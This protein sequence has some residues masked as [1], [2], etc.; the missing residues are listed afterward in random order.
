MVFQ[1]NMTISFYS[2]NKIQTIFSFSNICLFWFCL[3]SGVE[4]DT[5]GIIEYSCN[6]SLKNK[7]IF[8]QKT[9]PSLVIQA[10]KY[11]INQNKN[12]FNFIFSLQNLG[13]VANFSSSIFQ[14]EKNRSELVPGSNLNKTQ[15]QLGPSIMYK[16]QKNN[17]KR[18]WWQTHTHAGISQE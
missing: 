17:F 10:Q 16:G 7:N 3:H 6:K 8:F 4:I 12:K 1:W 15:E 11:A 18:F 2:S 9:K 5:K 13:N 14:K